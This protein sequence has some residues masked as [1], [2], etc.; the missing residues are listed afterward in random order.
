MKTPLVRRLAALEV[1]APVVDQVPPRQG[2]EVW[3][4]ILAHK[5]AADLLLLLDRI[6]V[7][8]DQGPDQGPAILALLEELAARLNTHEG[9]EGPER[10]HPR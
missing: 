2:E 8:V 10:T 9:Q 4:A 7:L 3:Q 6:S 5:D 1:R